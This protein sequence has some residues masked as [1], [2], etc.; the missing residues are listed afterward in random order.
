[1]TV[2]NDRRTAALTELSGPILLDTVP[3][4]LNTLN[5]LGFSG[6]KLP[7]RPD[8]QEQYPMNQT[9]SVVNMR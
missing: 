3:G 1:M 8:V 4:Q 9:V 5:K 2:F 6:G 7:T